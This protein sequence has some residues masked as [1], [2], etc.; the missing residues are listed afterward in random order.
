MMIFKSKIRILMLKITI[1]VQLHRR[2]E[3]WFSIKLKTL[4]SSGDKVQLV[5]EEVLPTREV[6]AFAQPPR[7]SFTVE[8]G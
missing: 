1:G 6:D 3:I 5:I 7:C 4:R 2:G 8:W